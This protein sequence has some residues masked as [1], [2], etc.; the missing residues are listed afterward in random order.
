MKAY[1][2]LKD[3]VRVYEAKRKSIL[4]YLSF[5]GEQ[6]TQEQLLSL[7]SYYDLKLAGDDV[8]SLQAYFDAREQIFLLESGFDHVPDS[9]RKEIAKDK[10]LLRLSNEELMKKHGVCY[11]T[12]KR[13]VRE[14]SDYL[15]AYID[16]YMEWKA[17]TLYI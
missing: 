14:T 7:E 12:I 13:A 15:A 9:S 4:Q 10:M 3:R 5:S 11:K 16:L 6:L 17:K 2:S 1:P 8:R